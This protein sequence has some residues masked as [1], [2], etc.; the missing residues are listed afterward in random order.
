VGG[1]VT[2]SS[3][4][5]V[6]PWGVLPVMIAALALAGGWVLYENGHFSN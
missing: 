2:A 5:Y 1:L 4:T 6:G 3:A